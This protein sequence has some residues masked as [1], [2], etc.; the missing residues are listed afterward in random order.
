MLPELPKQN[1]KQETL[2]SIKFRHWLMAHPMESC[3]FEIKSTRGK[4][5]FNLRE[6]KENQ[7]I[8]ARAVEGEK[9][10]LIRCQGIGGN[11]DYNYYRKA[12]AYVVIFYPKNFYVIRIK[13]L[14]KEKSLTEQKAK[15]LSI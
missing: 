2:A 7:I 6:L 12:P 4:H 10:V 11:A 5:T 1:K 8:F 15:E 3:T 14:P 9:G 13:D